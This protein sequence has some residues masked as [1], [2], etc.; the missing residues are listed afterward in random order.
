[1]SHT[2]IYT[3]RLSLSKHI[4]E[5]SQVFF[6]ESFLTFCILLVVFPWCLLTCLSSPISSCK[7]L[8]RSKALI[9]FQFLFFFFTKI[10][11]E[12]LNTGIRKQ[13]MAVCP[14]FYNVSSHCRSLPELTV[15]LVVAKWR[16]SHSILSLFLFNTSLKRMVPLSTIT[17]RYTLHRKE[18]KM[19]GSFASSTFKRRS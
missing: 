13:A 18:G 12:W 15:S 4:V 19:L 8:V 7:L 17:L 5:K 9:T 10:L 3:P 6:P 1:M 2:S 14:S 11:P 16:H